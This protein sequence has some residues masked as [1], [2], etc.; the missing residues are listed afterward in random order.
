MKEIELKTSEISSKTIT[1]LFLYGR[2]TASK[3]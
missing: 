1:N 3:R 2:K